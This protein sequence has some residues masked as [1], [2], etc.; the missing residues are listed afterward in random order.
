MSKWIGVELDG[1][2]AEMGSHN[3]SDIGKPVDGM[4]NRVKA[5]LNEGNYEV[6]IFTARAGDPAQVRK[7]NDW[8]SQYK[9]GGLTVTNIKDADMI[10]LWDDKAVRV[11]RNT[12]KVCKGCANS[13][14][15]ASGF[16]HRHFTMRDVEQQTDC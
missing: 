10:E 13:E 2:L 9:L 6:R 14:R 8:L 12:G 3:R 11:E 16:S 4:L 15:K 1:T 5:W 7:V